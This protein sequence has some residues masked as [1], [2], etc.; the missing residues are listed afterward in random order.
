MTQTDTQ[1]SPDANEPPTYTP[2]LGPDKPTTTL[3]MDQIELSDLEQ[4]MTPE[5]DG[6]FAKLRDEAPITFFEEPDYT[7]PD[8][9]IA[10]LP[11]GPGYW[12][13]TR[14][15]DAM[16]V[17]RDPATF[18][19]APSINIADIP[20]DVAEWLGSMINMDAPKHT[21][22]RLIVNRGFTPRQVARIEELVHEQAREIADGLVEK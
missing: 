7:D 4:W 17:S 5:R 11:P 18:H 14:Y 6:I 12:A 19:S 16:Q 10:F 15:A 9:G 1:V 8:T 3:G 13:V 20:A 22:L 2:Y 21:K